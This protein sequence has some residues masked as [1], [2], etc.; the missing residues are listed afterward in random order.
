M[1]GWRNNAEVAQGKSRSRRYG[2]GR[3]IQLTE[4]PQTS[5]NRE[6]QVVSSDLHRQPAA[7]GGGALR[8]RDTLDN[9]LRSSRQTQNMAAATP[10]AQTVS[11]RPAVGSAVTGPEGYVPTA[12]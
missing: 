7:G 8:L 3:R 5:L 9:H 2:R 6:W 12:P 1:E 11:G 10:A 4:H